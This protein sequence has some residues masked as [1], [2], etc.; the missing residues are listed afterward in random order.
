MRSIG[1]TVA[2]VAA[3]ILLVPQLAAATDLDVEIQDMKQRMERMEDQLQAQNDQ[4]ANA[5]AT[6]EAQQQVIEDAGLDEER[7]EQSAL[8]SFLEQTEFS[9]WV[10][11]SYVI[12]FTSVEDSAPGGENGQN[13]SIIPGVGAG[14]PL[15][16]PHHPDSNTF[17]LDQAW[18]SIDKAPT[19]ESRGGFHMDLRAGYGSG[20]DGFTPSF[21]S[22]YASYLIPLMQGL[23]IDGGLL[24]TLVG[25]E[26]EQT[27]ANFN[28]TRGLVWGLQPIT[29]VGAVAKLDIGSGF[30]VAIGALNDVVGGIGIDDTKAPALTSQVAY[31]ADKYFASATFVYGK[32]QS[33]PTSIFFP[34]FTGGVAN[35]SMGILDLV[36]TAD[37]VENLSL[38]I[39]YDYR[40]ENNKATTTSPGT[41]KTSYQAIAGA[42]RLSVLDNA[43]IALRYEYVS[44]KEDIPLLPLENSLQ[45]VTATGDYSPI[46]GLTLKLEYRFDY[47]NID[48]LTQTAILSSTGMGIS[49]IFL[50]QSGPILK[51]TQHVM[52]LQ[53]M[54]EF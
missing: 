21:Y 28:I 40:W 2:I 46:D 8:S 3:S 13:T 53:M 31:S 36:L 16:Y 25:A 29:N 7:G 9:G 39:N 19:E 10:A 20:A 48:L 15:W 43:G 47:S 45:S 30:S 26:V 24:P 33:A 1:R 5:E 54:Y 6:V 44:Y 11:A 51:D 42:G 50:P 22:A 27:N 4:I 37:P 18:I 52:L 38:W 49:G 12:N 17:Q 23:Q 34:V 35:D 41:L 32:D 14:F